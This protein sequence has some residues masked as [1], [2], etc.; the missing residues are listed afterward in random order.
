M[1]KRSLPFR[2]SLPTAA[3]GFAMLTVGAG[4]GY[5]IGARERAIDWGATGTFLQGLAALLAAAVAAWGVNRWQQE[6]RFKRNSELAE[7]VMV[8]VEALGDAIIR[9]RGEPRDYET[10]SPLGNLR[11]LT[12]DSY[13]HR[14]GLLEHKDY[15]AELRTHVHRVGVLFGSSYRFSLEHLLGL[16]DSLRSALTNA[17]WQAAQ[18]STG[19]VDPLAIAAELTRLAPILFEDIDGS[20]SDKFGKELNKAFEDVRRKFRKDL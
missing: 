20:D 6:L 1:D 5:V 14:I 9:T 19:R 8:C 18:L 13:L 2:V 17:S 10:F 16:T 3:V 15:A 11:V 7:K 4:C 12:H